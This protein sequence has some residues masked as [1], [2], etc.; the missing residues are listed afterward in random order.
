MRTF[1]DWMQ[2]RRVAAVLAA[3]AVLVVVYRFTP[4]WGGK[5]PPAPTPGA[6]GKPQPQGISAGTV[7]STDPSVAGE[8]SASVAPAGRPLAWSWGR[9]PFLPQWKE[10]GADG[11]GGDRTGSGS[12]GGAVEPSMGLRG[13]VITGNSGIAIFGNRLVP[14]GGKLGDWTVERVDPYSVAL[15]NGKE[16][17]VVELYKPAPSG[18]KGRGGDR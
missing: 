9:N 18:G 7:A 11:I 15:R 13:T 12:A 14:V 6:E 3:V 5:T 10:R 4:E 1:R 16:V 8:A 2:D 17:R